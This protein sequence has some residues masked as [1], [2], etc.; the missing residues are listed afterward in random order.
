MSFD[1]KFNVKNIKYVQYNHMYLHRLTSMRPNLLEL[2]NKRW[3]SE[4]NIVH[5]RLIDCEISQ[6]QISI[7]I[8]TIF[9]QMDLKPSVILD[10]FIFMFDFN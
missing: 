6:G 1:S 4:C 2:A 3:K 8:G 7:I 10:S 9:K 5:D